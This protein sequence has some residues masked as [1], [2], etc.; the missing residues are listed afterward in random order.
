VRTWSTVTTVWAGVSPIRGEERIAAQGTQAKLTHRVT[1][2]YGA[3]PNLDGSYRFLMGSRIFE[4][5]GPPVNPT[6]RNIQWICD[7]REVT[8]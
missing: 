8:E 5:T 1:L 6:E 2:R 4:I 3:F 7:C